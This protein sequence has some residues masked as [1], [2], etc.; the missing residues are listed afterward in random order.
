MSMEAKLDNQEYLAR[1]NHFARLVTK[2]CSS[3]VASSIY[4]DILSNIER[5]GDH[6]CNIARDA[7]EAN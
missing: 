4:A 6:C 1:R 3:A 2:E 5:I 7:F